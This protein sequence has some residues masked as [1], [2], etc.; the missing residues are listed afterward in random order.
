MG[1]GKEIWVERDVEVRWRFGKKD[2]IDG[3]IFIVASLQNMS[4]TRFVVPG[5][6]ELHV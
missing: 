6:H 4:I 3:V 2:S 1:E 5:Y